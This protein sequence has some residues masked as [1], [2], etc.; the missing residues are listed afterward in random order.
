MAATPSQSVR[1]VA[2]QYVDSRKTTASPI[3]MRHALLALRTA[4]PNCDLSDHE[5]MDLVREL[6]V[7]RG[8]SVRFDAFLEVNR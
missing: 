1:Q 6:A 8:R 7:V 2:E 3:S 5:L 4:M